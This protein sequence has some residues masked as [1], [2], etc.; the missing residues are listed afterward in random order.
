MSVEK[1][2][3]PN[4]Y[5]PSGFLKAISFIPPAFVGGSY[6]LFFKKNDIL[7]NIFEVTLNLPEKRLIE[8]GFNISAWL[9]FPVAMVIDKTFLFYFKKFIKHEKT[10]K[11]EKI[12]SKN[13]NEMKTSD[14]LEDKQL[15][16][17]KQQNNNSSS[18][19]TLRFFLNF[20]AVLS[21]FAAICFG[22]VSFSFSE[23]VCVLSFFSY[24]I[25]ISCYLVMINL[26]LNQLS[27]HSNSVRKL[28][29][30]DWIHI[31][32]GPILLF[33]VFG[34][35]KFNALKYMKIT[36]SDDIRN[37]YKNSLNAVYFFGV[38]LIFT[39]F[40]RIKQK[41]PQI[42]VCLAKKIKE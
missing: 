29:G 23:I 19:S 42:K 7:P 40:L 2:R 16:H 3:I 28:N 4:F 13:S 18:F 25:F 8:V 26:L 1:D 32:I 12:P 15:K 24:I 39:N 30:F 5:N 35:E 20:F 22:F 33:I 37:I 9:L 38:C 41:L 10:K 11:D 6:Y 27:H 36:L 34:V 17:N 31:F 21:F 14:N